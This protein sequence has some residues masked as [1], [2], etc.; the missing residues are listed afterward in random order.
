MLGVKK[1]ASDSEIKKSY[2]QLAKKYHPDTNKVRRPSLAL[3]YSCLHSLPQVAAK[4]L[5]GTTFL[6]YGLPTPCP[7]RAGQP[8]RSGKVSGRE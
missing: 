7:C 8:G 4:Q 1:D 6:I 2:Y 3:D 5:A